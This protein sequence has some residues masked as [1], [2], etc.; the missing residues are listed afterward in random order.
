MLLVVVK[1]DR[2]VLMA[3]M[4]KTQILLSFQVEMLVVLKPLML[5]MVE[6]VAKAVLVVLL[7]RLLK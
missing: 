2:V 5:V 4:V 3:Q 1:V 7:V 6:K